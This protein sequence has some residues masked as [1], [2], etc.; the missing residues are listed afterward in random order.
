MC[1]TYIILYLPYLM[2]CSPWI[3]MNPHIMIVHVLSLSDNQI[4]HVQDGKTALYI[5]S[6]KGHGP[7]VEQLLQ[8]EHTDV[9]INMEVYNY[10]TRY[11]V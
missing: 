1:V 9:N 4:A 8:M 7:V 6:D 5:A 11:I 10:D 3:E 2:M